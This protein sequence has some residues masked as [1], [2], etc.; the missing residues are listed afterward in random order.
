MPLPGVTKLPDSVKQAIIADSIA[1]VRRDEIA[2]KYNVH[3]TSISRWVSKF[4][5]VIPKGVQA[6]SSVEHLKQS[7]IDPSFQA[8]KRSLADASSSGS[9]KAAATAIAC[10]KGI[11]VFAPDVQSNLTLLA[12]SVP[13]DW[14]AMLPARPVQALP[15]APA[16]LAPTT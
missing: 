1:G 13:A 7:L 10:L 3:P 11:G 4:K 6:T 16:D 2:T 8:L 15:A 5:A 9:H 14:R 12:G